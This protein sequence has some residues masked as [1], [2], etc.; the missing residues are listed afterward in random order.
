MTP[1]RTPH[2]DQDTTAMNPVRLSKS[3]QQLWFAEQLGAHPAGYLVPLPLRLSGPLDAGALH[4]ALT[5]LVARHEL[6]RTSFRLVDGEPS[7]VLRPAD[8]F[9]LTVEDATD[10]PGAVSIEDLVLAE[11]TAPM[12]VADGL[13]IRARLIRLA[14]E[15][16]LLLVTVHHLAFDD[17]SRNVLYTELAELYNAAVTGR[18]A[19]LAP[20]G[21]SY[22]QY[23]AAQ[24]DALQDDLGAREHLD[25]WRT[26]LDGLDPFE[27]L[28]EL[29]RPAHR[30]GAGDVTGFVLPRPQAERLTALGRSV[31]ATPAMVLFAACQVALRQYTGRDDVTV[32][33]A[34]AARDTD[35]TASMIGPLLTMLV[36]RGDTSGDPTFTEAVERM[37]DLVLDAFEHAEVPFPRL[38]EEFAP[39]RDPSRT[40]LFQ[41]IVGYG[42]GRRR[43]PDLTGLT[44]TELPVP[45]VGSKYDLGLWFDHLADGAIAVDVAWDVSL[46]RPGTMHGFAAHLRGILAQAAD[47]GDRRIGDLEPAPEARRTLARFS[48]GPDRPA[49]R[50]ALHERFTAQA[51]RTPDAVALVLADGTA[52]TYAQLDRQADRIAH[53]LRA[54]G[55][56]PETLVGVHAERSTELVAALYGVLK[57]GGA[58]VPLDPEHP[59]ERLADLLTDTGTRVILTQRHLT[60]ALPPTDALILD[61]DDPGQWTDAPAAAPAAAPCDLDNTAY[62]I[63]TSG[64]TGRPKSVVLTHRNAAERLDWLQERYPLRPDD[65]FLQRSSL[66][67]DASVLEFFWPLTVGAR[68]VLPARDD[69]KDTGRLRDLIR[70]HGVTA[71]QF[72]PSMLALLLAERGIEECTTLR[73]VV[74]CGE[75]VPVALAR[76][77]LRVLPHCELYNGYGPTEATVCVNWWHCTPAALAGLS[78]VPL[79]TPFGNTATHILDADLRPVPPG[80]VG[81]LFLGGTGVAR[82]YLNRPGLTAERFLPDPFSTRPGARLYRSG[83]LVRLRPD[84]ASLDF[85]GR[86]DQQV[87]VRGFRVELGEIDAALNTHPAVRESATTVMTVPPGDPRLVS[88][89]VAADGTPPEPDTLRTFVE[90]RLPA[91]AVPS[92]VVVVPELPRTASGK[93]NRA[94]L[95]APDLPGAAAAGG[96]PRDELEAWLCEVWR[97]V[98]GTAQVGIHDSFFALGGHSLL[99]MRTVNRLRDD[100][101]LDFP[102]SVLFESPTVAALAPRLTELLILDEAAALG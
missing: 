45:G 18:P 11:A 28:P 91:H 14:D 92:A 57:A 67:F 53:R 81:E 12:D 59:R 63:S 51:H 32:G 35:H 39:E 26:Q 60:A 2:D 5:A 24:Q 41:V 8:H 95:P 10:A 46:Y 47:D 73:L 96:E 82:G 42:S 93:L 56:G 80:A 84:G 79:G 23:T 48:A 99:A 72:V 20:L 77:L 68:L 17:W 43:A 69:H 97:E 70:T 64:S 16:H 4:S 55:V 29:P 49:S 15:L 30:S 34:A 19:D 61:L 85:L 6:L 3:Q 25:Y 62:T 76:D 102:M 54:A 75:E 22:A 38:V 98:L 7:G 86:A 31:G 40:P 78:T 1:P 66:S 33:T 100:L 89:V 88:Y 83:D 44:V 36:L 52:T 37:R 87:K 94:A 21:I 90:R 71:A 13:P 101:G 50:A 9:A 27:L 74:A 58:Y 65:A